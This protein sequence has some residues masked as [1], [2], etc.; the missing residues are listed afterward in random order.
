MPKKK[1]VVLYVQ[2]PVL[3]FRGK[4]GKFVGCCPACNLTLASWELVGKTQAKCTR[5]ETTSPIKKLKA[6]TSI[7]DEYGLC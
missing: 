4:H 3:E 6:Y 7:N 1:K 2:Q 5:C